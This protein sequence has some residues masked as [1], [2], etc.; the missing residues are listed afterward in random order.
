ML[1][2]RAPREVYRV[3]SEDEFFDGA[4]NEELFEPVAP[5]GTGERRLR[6]LAGAAMLVGAVG[7]VGGVIAINISR[8]A[9]NAARRASPDSP[10]ATRS[11]ITTRAS[12]VAHPYATRPVLSAQVSPAPRR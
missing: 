8:P 9:R 11:Y 4:T 3:Y 12:A 2:R 5:A 7:T 6:R 10:V 1:L